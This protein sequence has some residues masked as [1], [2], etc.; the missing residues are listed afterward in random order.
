MNSHQEKRGVVISPVST[1]KAGGI[2][3]FSVFGIKIYLNYTW[4]IVVLLV[5]WSL[6]YGYFPLVI[7]GR[8]YS[9]YWGLGLLT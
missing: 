3:L 1:L 7:P 2:R 4:F 5:A 6:S 8:S 9:L